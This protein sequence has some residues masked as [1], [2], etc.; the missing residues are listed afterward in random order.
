MKKRILSLL[1]CGVLAVSSVAGLAACNKG[2][3]AIKL[4]VW[5]SAAQQETF[6]QMAEEFKKANPDKTYEIKIGIG[7]EDM[8]YSNVSKDP[9]A[10]AD[11]YCYSNDQLMPLLRVG[12]LAR[13]GG[14]YLDNIKARTR[15]SRARSHG[16]RR[17]R[18][19]TAIRTLRTTVTLCSTI[20]RL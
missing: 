19:C 13:I 10:A 20:S 8:A 7:E 15:R 5:G 4:T 12:A 3:D 9:S 2:G 18:K 17:T 14:T 1:A 16:E 6:K 11:V